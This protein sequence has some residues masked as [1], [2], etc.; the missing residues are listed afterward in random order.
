LDI[1]KQIREMIATV[2][3][4]KT[5]KPVEQTE[6]LRIEAIRNVVTRDVVNQ[7]STRIDGGR[8]TSSVR[9]ARTTWSVRYVSS[10]ISGL[11]R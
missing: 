10:C 1:T 6:A 9:W 3:V 11:R 8:W 2:E 4:P 5:P 7:S